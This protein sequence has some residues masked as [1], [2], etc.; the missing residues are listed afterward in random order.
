MSETK[1]TNAANKDEVVAYLIRRAERRVSQSEAIIKERMESL[2]SDFNGQFE[3][4]AETI[5]KHNLRL[6]YFRGLCATLAEEGCDKDRARFLLK[7]SVEH[8]ADDIMMCDPYRDSSNPA[9]NLA[10]R[11]EYEAKKEIRGIIINMLGSIPD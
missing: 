11:W 7:H 4:D 5:Y 10:H 6:D 2:T 1:N 9:A 8:L 3:W